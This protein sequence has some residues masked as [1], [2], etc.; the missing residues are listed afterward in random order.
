MFFFIIF[1]IFV[2]LIS[3]IIIIIIIVTITDLEAQQNL[4]F[5]IKLQ[6]NTL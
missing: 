4:Q 5:Y 1:I 3:D 6:Y 2:N